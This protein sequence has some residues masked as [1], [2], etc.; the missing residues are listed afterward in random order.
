M[1]IDERLD[2][3]EER[4]KALDRDV[5][6]VVKNTQELQALSAKNG[7]LIRTLLDRST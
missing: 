3:L 2:L 5:E 6:L 4:Q 7:E 1:T